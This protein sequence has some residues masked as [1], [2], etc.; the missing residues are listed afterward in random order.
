MAGQPWEPLANLTT[1][2]GRQF[3]FQRPV[4]CVG[5]QEFGEKQL[6]RSRGSR[7]RLPVIRNSLW[8]ARSAITT[9]WNPAPTVDPRSGAPTVPHDNVQSICRQGTELQE[10]SA[11]EPSAVPYLTHTKLVVS[12]NVKARCR[13]GR[14]PWHNRVNPRFNGLFIREASFKS[15]RSSMTRNPVSRKARRRSG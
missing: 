11:S 12:T 2:C 10:D 9:G 4:A 1:D 5:A 3:G 7:V 13:N 15:K 14:T 6:H 8:M